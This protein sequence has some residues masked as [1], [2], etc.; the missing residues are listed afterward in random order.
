MSLEVLVNYMLT[1][2]VLHLFKGCNI[3]A[4]ENNDPAYNRRFL[5]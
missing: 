5:L 4:L 1:K 3:S 2:I